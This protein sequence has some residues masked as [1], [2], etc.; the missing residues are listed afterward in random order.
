MRVYTCMSTHFKHTYRNH[1]RE[2]HVTA[3]EFNI[4]NGGDAALQTIWS[5]VTG[6]TRCLLC[7]LQFHSEVSKPRKMAS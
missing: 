5:G 3:L 2:L 7:K 6:R 4:S 1:I